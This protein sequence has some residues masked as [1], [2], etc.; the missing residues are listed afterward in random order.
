M[1]R[2]RRRRAGV[3]GPPAST[4]STPPAPTAASRR[5]PTP[6]ATTPSTAWPTATT[7][8]ARSTIWS[9]SATPGCRP[10]LARSA[11]ARRRPGR[12]ARAA[13]G[14]G[15]SSVHR[16]R[17]PVSS[18]TGP[19]GLRVESYDDAITAR[20]VHDACR[21]DAGRRRGGDGDRPL[22]LREQR[23]RLTS[24]AAQ[25]AATRTTGP[26]SA[27]P[28]WPGSTKPTRSSSTSTDT[29]GACTTRT[30]SSRARLNSYLR[31]GGSRAI[32][33]WTARIRGAGGS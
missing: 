3:G 20:E 30:C 2:T 17:R 26:T 19:S 28:T 29:P 18:Y 24:A 12:P 21:R 15:R 33:G 25:K 31:R 10:P 5:P 32:R 6:R 1:R 8:R 27:S 22:R 13:S 16:S 7:G 9:A 23:G 14:G 11:P 4:C